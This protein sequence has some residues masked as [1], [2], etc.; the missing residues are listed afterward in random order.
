MGIFPHK[1][2]IFGLRPSGCRPRWRGRR[3]TPRCS[4]TDIRCNFA[5]NKTDSYVLKRPHCTTTTP[6]PTRRA[7]NDSYH[8]HRTTPHT[9]HSVAILAQVVDYPAGYSAAWVLSDRHFVQATCF[10]AVWLAFVVLLRNAG[11]GSSTSCGWLRSFAVDAPVPLLVG[12]S[13]FPRLEVISR[14]EIRCRSGRV[15]VGAFWSV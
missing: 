14:F 10:S 1:C 4:A 15:A 7:L 3:V 12:G 8:P 9:P 13:R 6:P 11:A 2:D 5:R